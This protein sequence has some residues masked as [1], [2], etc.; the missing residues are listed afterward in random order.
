MAFRIVCFLAII[1]VPGTGP[2]IGL[3][4][5]ATLLPG[6]AVLVAN[7]VDRRSH[8]PKAFETGAP[9]P[10]KAL[11]REPTPVV[12]GEVVDD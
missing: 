11:T 3:L 7:A 10:R 1:V 6:I 5:A 12:T 9:E 4:V 2:K 8:V